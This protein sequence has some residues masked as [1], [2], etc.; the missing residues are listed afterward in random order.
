VISTSI[1][2]YFQEPLR[3]TLLTTHYCTLLTV[4]Q[5]LRL[6]SVAWPRDG[7]ALEMKLR[8]GERWI[9]GHQKRHVQRRR[10]RWLFAFIALTLSRIRSSSMI[11]LN[12]EVHKPF[13]ALSRA[14][15]EML[16]GAGGISR[17]PCASRSCMSCSEA[18]L[19]LDL[20]HMAT[21]TGTYSSGH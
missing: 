3:G 17:Y 9:R 7:P 21:G 20:P 16:H 15:H 18:E 6:H 5:V 11:R 12:I 14:Q 13:Y 4:L 8:A 19:V 2:Y 1:R 10:E